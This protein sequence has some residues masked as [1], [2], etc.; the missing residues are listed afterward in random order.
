[1]QYFWDWAVRPLLNDRHVRGV[2]EIGASLGGNT[3]RLLNDS[4]GIQ[5]TVIDPCL[6]I[7]LGQK[8]R[9][10]G[11]VRVHAARSLEVLPTLS[12]RYD[13]ILIDGDHNYY[14]V[15]NE[16]KHIA[17]RSLVSPGGVVLLH[18]VGEPYARKDLYYEPERIPASAK[19]QDAPHGVLSAVEDFLK[20]ADPRWV[21]LIWRSEHGLGC[22]INGCSPADLLFL[23]VKIFLWRG[24]RWKNRLLR[25]A[26]LRQPDHIA[27]GKPA[28]S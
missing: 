5:I 7:D 12:G 18:D 28:A 6:D 10:V 4:P 2:L 3:D 24:I 22:L 17:E 27:W 11:N 1:M 15:S 13:A 8:Y 26:G 25:Y 14:T 16:L 21:W 20:N 19:T 23:R 9:G